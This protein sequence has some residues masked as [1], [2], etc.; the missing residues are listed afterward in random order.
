MH[1]AKLG[2]VPAAQLSGPAAQDAACE[3]QAKLKRA[4][5]RLDHPRQAAR[6]DLD[7]GRRQSPLALWR[8]Q[9]RPRRHARSAGDG[10]PAHRAR[11][12]H[13]DRARSS[14]TAASAT[15]SIWNGVLRPPPTMPK[16][17]SSPPPTSA[18]PKPKC[19]RHCP[20]S[21]APSCSAR[22]PSPPSR[23]TANAPTISPAPARPSN[24]PPRPVTIESSRWS[25]TA[26]ERS[27]FEMACEKGTYVRSLAR[28]LAEALG[29]RG[30][31]THAPP[32]RR[33]R[34]HRGR[35]DHHRGDRSRRRIATPCCA[36]PP[37]PCAICP[38]CASPPRT[39]RSSATAASCCCAARD[40]PI[41][42]DDAWASLNGTVV[43]LGSV[44]A[45]HFIP[46]RVLRG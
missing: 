40:A 26:P 3:R 13:Q 20:P 25:R 19:S 12:G 43:A 17:K 37:S 18:R 28:D 34:L 38:N 2:P 5:L 31:V 23:S 4:H 42:L 32:H 9:G 44:R 11:R 8:R 41:A 21:P 24:S 33:R 14:R 29:T 30:H 15:A 35:C 36:H 22:P 39:R 7:A 27:R 10:P 1:P 46:S 45:G 16:A 6:H